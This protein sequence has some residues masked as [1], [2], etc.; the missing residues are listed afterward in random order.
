MKV[1]TI[2]YHYLLTVLPSKVE[3]IT[4]LYCYWLE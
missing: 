2:Y 3:V 4:I 1:S